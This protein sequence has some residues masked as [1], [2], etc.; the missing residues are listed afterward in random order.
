MLNFD[1]IAS[2]IKFVR[3][4]LILLSIQLLF[5][6]CGTKRVDQRT[7]GTWLSTP[8]K[9]TVR[10]SPRPFKFE[11]VSDTVVTRLVIHEDKNVTGSVGG[12]ELK[13]GWIKPNWLLDP[14]MTL[15]THNISGTLYGEIFPGDP[16]HKKVVEFWIG[17]MEDSM[18]DVELRY[19]ANGS[20][21]P[22]ASINFAK[23][24]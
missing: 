6:S 12:A 10:T 15:V 16:L 20:A 3:F 8:H 24:E 11:F 5:P 21:F 19:T 4:T 14:E 13:G 22:M 7:H 1:E 2:M 17:P 18:A 23:V 9:V